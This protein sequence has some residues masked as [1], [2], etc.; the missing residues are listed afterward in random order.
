[1][2]DGID[3]TISY[4]LI[5]RYVNAFNFPMV[6]GMVPPVPPLIAPLGL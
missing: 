2:V 4:P 3:P 5:E 6:D 1:M